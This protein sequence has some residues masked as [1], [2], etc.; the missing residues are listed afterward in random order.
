[1]IPFDGENNVT[2]R[3][4]RPVKAVLAAKVT[5][6]PI[7]YGTKLPLTE[8]IKRALMMKGII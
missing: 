8:R 1:M 2:V 4:P 7:M 3:V 6:E 5:D